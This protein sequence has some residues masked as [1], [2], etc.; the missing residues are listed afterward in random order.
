MARIIPPTQRNLRFPV[1]FPSP[2]LATHSPSLPAAPLRRRLPRVERSTLVLSKRFKPQGAARTTSA[3]R[4][5]RLARAPAGPHEPTER[6]VNLTGPRCR[7]AGGTPRAAPARHAAAAARPS[8]LAS[9]GR[10]SPSELRD[11]DQARAALVL[12]CTG[13]RGPRAGGCVAVAC[14]PVLRYWNGTPAV[15]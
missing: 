3:R 8:A 4:P 13:R 9:K 14:S 1:T 5:A 6:A 15:G 2:S 12:A 11:R 7:A 10:T